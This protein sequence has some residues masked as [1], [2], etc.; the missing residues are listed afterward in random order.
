MK[1]TTLII[2]FLTVI[3]KL[4]GTATRPPYDFMKKHLAYKLVDGVLT[5]DAEKTC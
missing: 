5:L 3:R 2:S 4:K 1:I